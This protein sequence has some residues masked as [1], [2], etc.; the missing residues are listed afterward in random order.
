M[1]MVEKNIPPQNLFFNFFIAVFVNALEP[2]VNYISG[3]T[4]T[5]LIHLKL[6]ITSQ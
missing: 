2:Y 6:T 1:L 4:W 3:T 5:I